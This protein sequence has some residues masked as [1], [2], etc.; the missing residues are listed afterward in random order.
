MAACALPVVRADAVRSVG[1]TLFSH[2]CAPYVQ[3]CESPEG[4]LGGEGGCRKP[5]KDRE[6]MRRF[7][8]ETVVMKKIQFSAARRV[9]M[10]NLGE[11]VE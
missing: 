11:A 9:N 5:E 2:P 7:C 10:L 6:F 1:H 3:M 8:R 4:M